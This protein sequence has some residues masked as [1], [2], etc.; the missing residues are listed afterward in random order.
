VQDL[1]ERDCGLLS[2]FQVVTEEGKSEGVMKNKKK[3]SFLVQYFGE[4]ES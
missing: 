2:I 4:K 1:N 3:D